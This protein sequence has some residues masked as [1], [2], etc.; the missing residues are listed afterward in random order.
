MRSLTNGLICVAVLAS[1][2]CGA[3][4]RPTVVA[5]AARS[6][7][8]YGPD[9]E[10]SLQALLHGHPAT[11]LVF[12]SAGCPCVRRYQARI[13]ALREHW[14][15]LGAQVVGI[16]A[17]A[18][19]TLRDVEAARRERHIPLPVYRDRGGVVAKAVNARSTPTVAVLLP[20][21]QVVYRGWIDNER[22]V[23]QPGRQ[24]WLD[25]ALRRVLAGDYRTEER[26]RW[27]C[28]ITGGEPADG[29]APAAD[30][31]CKTSHAK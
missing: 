24:P 22:D 5:P 15:P 27:G 29:A 10:T 23:G 3:P 6:A 14:G 26:P 8:L 4:Q 16:A 25:N 2:A 7:P 19:E 11:V 13:D 30:C 1:S 9:G 17:N 31:G 12:W 21:G 20:D 18:D 28:L